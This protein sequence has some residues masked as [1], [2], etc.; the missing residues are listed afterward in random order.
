MLRLHR[1]TLGSAAA[2][3]FLASPDAQAFSLGVRAGAGLEILTMTG[4]KLTR[5]DENKQ[6]T[7]DEDIQRTPLHFGADLVVT[8]VQFGNLGIS[9]LVGFRST[10]AKVEGPFNDERQ[11]NY[12]PVGASVDYSMGPLRLSGS[13]LY[14]LAM[15]PKLSVSSGSTGTSAELEVKNMSRLRFGAL[16]EFFFLKNLSVFA[17][18]DFVTGGF[19]NGPGQISV[20]DDAGG[21]LEVAVS[22]VQN[23]ISGFSFAA[24]IAYTYSLSKLDVAS[25]SSEAKK[26][27]KK[28]R[29][30]TK[31]K[32]KTKQ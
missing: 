28:L 17:G 32:K 25:V 12:L 9:G 23:K 6:I 24:G 10:S 19:E 4:I 1:I 13:V 11:F 7:T 22:G 5:T 18:G 20:N 26:Q 27:G 8:P 2:L 3:I 15:S 21:L 16:G 29:K 30:R 31:K 14:D